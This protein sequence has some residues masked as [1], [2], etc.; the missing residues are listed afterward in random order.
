M[1]P[2]TCVRPETNF[3]SIRTFVIISILAVAA[4]LYWSGGIAAKANAEQAAAPQP[5][6]SGETIT[7]TTLEDDSDFSGAQ[8]VGDLPGPDGRVSFREAVTAANNTTG[9]QTIAFA[10]PTAEFWLDTS[11]ALL[12]LEVNAFFLTDSDTTVDFTTQTINIGDTNPNGPE[13]GIYGLQ[14]NGAGVAAIFVNG[15]NCIIKGLGKVYQRGYAVQLVGDNNR[16]IGSQISGPLHFAVNIEGSGTTIP[17]GNVVGGTATGEGNTLTGLTIRG[18]ADANIVIGNFV[19]NGVNVQGATPFGVSVHNNRIGGPSAAERNVISG[20]GRYGEEGFPVG[21]QVSIIDADGTIVEGNYIGTTVDGMHAFSPQIGP[22]GVE[23]RDARHTVIRSNLIA[24]LRVVGRNHYEGQMFGEAIH[25]DAI[26]DNSQDTLIE[27]NSIGLAAD[28]ETPIV[29]R[30]GIRVVPLISSR[31]ALRTRIVSNHIASVETTGVTVGSQENGITITG[32]SIHDSGALGIDLLSGFQGNGGVTLNDPGDNDEGG[33]GLQNFPVLTS[34]TT[35]GSSITFQGT[36]DS[37]ASEQFTIEF[38]TN[39]VCDTSGFGEGAMFLGSTTVTTDG[40]GHATFSVT[41]PGA[42]AAGMQATATA[43]R[44]STGDTSEFSA[45]VAVTGGSTQTPTP[46]QTNTPTETPTNTPTATATNTATAT[47]TPTFTPTAT[48]TLTPTSTPTST[49]TF[50]PTA[51]ATFTPTVTPTSTPTATATFTPTATATFTPTVTPTFTSTAT[52]TPTAMTTP[53][54]TA[55]FTPT[56]TSTPTFTPTLT[57]TA[58]PTDTPTA[59]ATTTFTP[60]ATPTGTPSVPTA[61]DYDADGKS[62]ISV[63]RA[64]TGSW[65]LQRSLAGAA[66][67]SFGISTD[68]ITPADYDGDGKTDIAVYRPSTGIWYIFDSSTNSVSYKVFGV[69]ED[70]PTPADYDGDGRADISVF[71]ASI[72]MWYR[73]NSLRG[74]ISAVQFGVPEDKPV[75]GDFDG[76]GKDDIAVFRPSTGAWYVINSSDGSFV[77]ELFGLG[78]DLTVPADYDGDGKTDLAV[79]RPS[80]G[81]WYT[82][83]SNGS[84]YTAFPFGLAEDIPAPGD[85][86]GD[87]RADLSVFRPSD[88]TWYRQNS[89]DGSFFGHQ[90]GAD[91]DQPTQA[92]FRY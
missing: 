86:D 84:V 23:I 15:N 21:A 8:Q 38:F 80:N 13:V 2:T 82:R 51:T 78:T 16:V 85:F 10:I 36:L 57:P 11:L 26:N 45:C 83:N 68:K 66:G 46:T 76:D 24:G 58:T 59:T 89:S 60:T 77:G 63:F 25:V 30:S 40:A 79:F 61:F 74:S 65:Y 42:V 18:P 67:M 28:G 71:R 49:P 72:G 70:M 87:G 6:L 34:A 88:G 37:L 90:F 1:K 4:A 91:G 32:N 50:T 31:H 62:D 14:P 41:L 7:V 56:A 29:T 73:L 9:G 69:S 33:N 17:T 92:A 54:S 47:A 22:Y 12:K 27:S 20:A 52:S 64:S 44:Q 75:M 35:T 55:T 3:L 53:T 81:F 48:A 39:P 5:A 43:T 19:T